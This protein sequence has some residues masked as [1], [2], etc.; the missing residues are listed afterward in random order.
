MTMDCKRT[1]EL[2]PAHLDRELGLPES[3][4]IE[5]H[6][7]ACTACQKELASQNALRAA[8]KKNAAC[9]DA[10]GHLESRIRAAL[11]P[12]N[13]QPG[14][15]RGRAANLANRAWGPFGA[16]NWLNAGLTFA[17]VAALALSASLYLT[18]PTPSELLAE[19][20]IASHVRSLMVSHLA[21]VASSDRHT[22]K[23]WFNGKLDFSPTVN[24]LTA[25]GFPL[26]GGRLDYLDHRPVAA[27]VYRHRQHLINVYSWPGPAGLAAS[28]RQT[29]V[30]TLSSQGYQLMNW[31]EGG[32][33][34]WVISD[35]EPRE[36]M[37]LTN[38]LQTQAK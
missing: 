17:T 15:G 9:F 2:L 35:L 30:K 13:E 25:Q 20:V 29:T 28:G 27:L 38:I 34:Y 36:L 8:L 22:V 24:D 18:V 3:L 26:V 6:L 23:P 33:V 4:E 31:T 37:A 1:L 21:D 19:E 12:G 14:H 7:Q 11:P 10:P 5:Q 16:W 32:M